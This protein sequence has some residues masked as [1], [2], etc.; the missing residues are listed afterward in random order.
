MTDEIIKLYKNAGIEPSHYDACKI[1]DAYWLNEELANEYGTFDNYMKLNCI[2]HYQECTD[3]CRHAYDR[4]IYPPFTAE[5]Q[6]ELIKWCLFKYKYINYL[7][8]E[9]YANKISIQE[10]QFVSDDCDTLEEAIASF[11]NNMWKYLTDTEKAEIKE[12]LNDK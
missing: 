6:L 4:D 7:D 3:E 2:Y 10:T 8:I 9:N 5:K 11:I 1:E 12:I